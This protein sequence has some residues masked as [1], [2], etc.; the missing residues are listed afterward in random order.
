[1]SEDTLTNPDAMFATYVT[2]L[3]P[4]PPGL[5]NRCPILSAELFDGLDNLTMP[6]VKVSPSG[7]SQLIGTDMFAHWSCWSSQGKASQFDHVMPSLGA[8]GEIG[9]VRA[10]TTASRM[11][12]G[13]KVIVCF[14]GITMVELWC[15]G[16][17]Y[18]GKGKSECKRGI[19]TS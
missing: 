6:R 7:A 10:G 4:G 17:E 1:M 9:I 3:P 11:R 8:R 19:S 15:S 13:Y 14:R 16:S 12:K 2:A 5:I 18:Q